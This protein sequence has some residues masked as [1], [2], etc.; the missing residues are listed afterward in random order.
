V[1]PLPIDLETSM[2]APPATAAPLGNTPQAPA[3]PSARTADDFEDYDRDQWGRPLIVQLDDTGRP[4]MVAT[5]DGP[6]PLRL[7]Y[8]RA[9]RAGSVLEYQGALNSYHQRNVA[10]G[11]AAREDLYYL[12]KSVVE[13]GGAGRREMDKTVVEPA[14]AAAGASGAANMG[15]ALHSFAERSDR[16]E[17]V[18]PL[19]PYQ[20]SLDAYRK[21]TAGWIWV[22]IECRL[23]SD[24]FRMAGKADRLGR[25]PGFMVAPDG[26]II[27]PD[28]VL[29]L[30]LKTSSSDRY[31]GVKFAVQ[32]CVYAHG[33][34][35]DLKTYARTPTGARTDWALVIHVP[36]GGSSGALYWVN[37]RRGVELVGL[38]REVLDAQGERDLVTR[39][40]DTAVYATLE[41]AQAARAAILGGQ[42][43]G[44]TVAMPAADADEGDPEPST[45]APAAD[46][47]DV[48]AI[49]E[50]TGES[51]TGVELRLAQEYANRGI[52]P[53]GAPTGQAS[54]VLDPDGA[55][56]RATR[57]ER[58]LE[59]AGEEPVEL[60]PGGS[61]ASLG[62]TGPGNGSTVPASVTAAIREDLGPYLQAIERDKAV[63]QHERELN[64][65][66]S[67]GITSSLASV[68]DNGWTWTQEHEDA[69]VLREWE[70][71]IIAA[72]E[73]TTTEE[74][75]QGIAST[76]VRWERWTDE[77]RRLA[78][79]QSAILAARRADS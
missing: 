73:S 30:D 1:P 52:A 29:A 46:A 40:A 56:A 35:Y 42:P 48:A 66:R 13:P 54:Y 8:T 60:V 4:V 65:I 47:T 28:D 22:G 26:T 78:R 15:T 79:R 77:M 19:G 53:D 12:A 38:A 63:T 61:A 3:N 45:A 9:S 39:V 2:S 59:A 41:E 68:R 7:A 18:P 36:T 11:L 16:G 31:F 43:A 72:I 58:E 24:R 49:A 5:K 74:A 70:L 57:V 75:L 6:E 50:V 69:Y 51:E 71:E 55:H 37:L 14:K 10:I 23:I 17:L 76:V 25:P 34:L 27:T 20:A 32:L 64:V 33:A 67:A 62:W 21:I 44:I